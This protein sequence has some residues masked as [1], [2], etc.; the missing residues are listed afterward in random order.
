MN[1]AELRN[2]YANLLA[3]SMCTDTKDLVHPAY[4]DIIKQMTPLDAQIL[5]TLAETPDKDMAIIDLLATTTDNTSYITL[6]ENVTS[7]SI[8]SI[9]AISLS[10][11]NLRRHNL[12][13]ITTETYTGREAY[14]AIYSSE[15]YLAFIQKPFP[16]KYPNS[17]SVEKAIMMSIFGKSFYNICVSEDF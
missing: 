3:K 2:L 15:Q 5:R 10:I 4:V 14:D 11:A 1:S 16:P 17:L 9:E 8:A 12:I 7:L 13:S 6:L